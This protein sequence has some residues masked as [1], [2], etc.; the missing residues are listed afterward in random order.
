M[1]QSD[2][3]AMGQWLES[4]WEPDNIEVPLIGQL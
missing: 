1:A 2:I 4:F 3:A